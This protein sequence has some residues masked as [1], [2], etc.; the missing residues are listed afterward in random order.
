MKVDDITLKL[1]DKLLEINNDIDFAKDVLTNA[2]TEKSRR[3]I[4]ELIEE[5]PDITP[6]RLLLISVALG[7]YEKENGLNSCNI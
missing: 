3:D 4:L 7:Q 5:H 6:K 1:R 2:K